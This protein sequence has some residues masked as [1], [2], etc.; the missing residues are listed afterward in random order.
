MG[1]SGRYSILTWVACPDADDD[2]DDISP[3][4][5]SVLRRGMAAAPPPKNVLLSRR[6]GP[7][8]NFFLPCL[9]SL[10]RFVTLSAV[11]WY[12]AKARRGLERGEAANGFGSGGRGRR[13]G[14][15]RADA[16]SRR[17]SGP[18]AATTTTAS[19]PDGGRDPFLY[20]ESGGLCA[21]CV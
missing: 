1:R 21:A 11:A 3:N 9:P 8:Q 2:N 13:V 19:E 6:V 17:R 5:L 12:G 16:V 10:F 20:Y 7:P 14:G 18:A 15:K 4:N